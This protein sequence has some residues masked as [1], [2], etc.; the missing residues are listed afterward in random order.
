MLT[1]FF[2]GATKPVESS[3]PV[4]R[5]STSSSTFPRVRH[6][7]PLSQGSPH[8][9]RKGWRSSPTQV[10]SP[11]ILRLPRRLCS[12]TV[13]DVLRAPLTPQERVGAQV[14][15]KCCRLR[16]YVSLAVCAPTRSLTFSPFAQTP[17]TAASPRDT[18]LP[19]SVS[20]SL[21]ISSTPLTYLI[22]INTPA[23]LI[24]R[25]HLMRVASLIASSIASYPCCCDP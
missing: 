19:G 18:A 15:R 17:S 7:L 3:S 1:P 24:P 25:L 2:I 12:H 8:S 11:Q 4:S 13:A 6:L 16:F 22:H 9:S 20:T 10:L 21:P 14:L 23:V 5:A